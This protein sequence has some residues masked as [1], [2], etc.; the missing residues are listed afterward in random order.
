MP[1]LG[2]FAHQSR[3]AATRIK[4][5][6]PQLPVATCTCWLITVKFTIKVSLSK[7]DMG[8]RDHIEAIEIVVYLHILGCFLCFFEKSHWDLW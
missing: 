7:M 3:Q 5:T 2:E 8:N 4:N 1:Q 6:H